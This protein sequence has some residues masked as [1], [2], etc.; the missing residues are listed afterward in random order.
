[1]AYV[2]TIPAEYY[3]FGVTLAGVAV[4]HRYALTIALAGLGVLL[5]LICLKSGFVF[6]AKYLLAHFSH[7]WVV[8]ANLLLLLLGFAVLASQFELSNAADITP[9]ILPGGWLGGFSLLLLVAGLSIFLDNIAGAMIG[10]VIA[11]HVYQGRLSVGFLAA[12]VAAANAG[13]A[14]V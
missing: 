14:G 4:L 3:L 6:G 11:R 13:G 2:T 10:G 5:T 12:I 9:A 7:E 8:L 1:M